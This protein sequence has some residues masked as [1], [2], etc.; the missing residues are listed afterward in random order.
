[1]RNKNIPD[2]SLKGANSQNQLCLHGN[3]TFIE[4]HCGILYAISL[5]V[6]HN[7]KPINGKVSS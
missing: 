6:H 3:I 7:P 5:N 2:A 4:H 1:V